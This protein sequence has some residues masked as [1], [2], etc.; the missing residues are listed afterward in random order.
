[1]NAFELQELLE[2]CLPNDYVKSCATI[3][4]CRQMVAAIDVSIPLQMIIM[5]TWMRDIYMYLVMVFVR[6][7]EQILFTIADPSKTIWL[8]DGLPVC[9]L[10]NQL[11]EAS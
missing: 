8:Q 1:M 7:I 10:R 6:M 9:L 2:S 4:V 11:I 3:D 5:F